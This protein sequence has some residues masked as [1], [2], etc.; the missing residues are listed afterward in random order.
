MAGGAV[1][2]T[3][4]AMLGIGGGVFLI[5]LLNVGLGLPLKT[6][7][8]ISLMTVIATSNA[9]AANPESRKLL[10]LRLGMLL[11]VP[12]VAGGIVGALLVP[13]LQVG[14]LY[15]I[16]ATTTA[17]ISAVM[18]TR[19]DR[20][21]V[22]L[23]ASIEPGA[24]GGRFFDVQSGKDVAY[25]V[26]RLA[27][28]LGV[29]LGG[30]VI[31]GLLGIGGGILQ[32]PA[33]N[34]WCG[35]P[36]RVAAATTAAMIGVTALGSAPMYY[37]RGH[38]TASLAAAAVLGVLGGSRVGMWLSGRTDAKGLKILMA[39]VLAAVSLIYFYRSV[40]G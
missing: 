20:R 8:G 33:L 38:V 17:V 25:R 13:H 10:N 39:A 27:A 34:A 23:D 40:A 32:V 1:A 37:M 35:I 24:L 4:G 28:G 19:L 12:A 5:P 31:S 7:S 22:I 16:F 26:R 14:T 2:G 15:L 36:M 18:F 30:G 29:S 3:L 9:V 11:Q 6:A 21:N